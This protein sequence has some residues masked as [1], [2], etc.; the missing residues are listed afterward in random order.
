MQCVL[1]CD[2]QG[3]RQFIGEISARGTIDEHFG[4]SQQR[5]ETREPDVCL[6]P[7]PMLVKTGD[8]AQSIVSAT[9]GIAGE[10]IQRFEL[11]EDSDV[12]RGTEG[13]LH[14]IEGDDLVAQQKRAQFI[15]A[16]GEGPHNVIVPI[17]AVL[18]DRNYNKSKRRWLP[19]QKSMSWLSL[20]GSRGTLNL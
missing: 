14:F 12:D 19:L 17:T 6:R 13:L 18:P 3:A 11:A 4:G 16:V 5:A 2:V 9:M 8:F 7:Q 1:Y 15:G 20:W 10:V